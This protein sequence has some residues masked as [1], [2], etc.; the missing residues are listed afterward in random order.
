M[1]FMSISGDIETP[2]FR[3]PT[4]DLNMTLAIAWAEDRRP[5]PVWMP[6][7]APASPH[8]TSTPGDTSSEA[9]RTCMR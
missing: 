5:S 7:S 1:G 8:G 6:A 4:A 3:P 9:R 2:L